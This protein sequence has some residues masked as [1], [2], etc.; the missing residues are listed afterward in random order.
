[1]LTTTILIAVAAIGAVAVAAGGLA[2]PAAEP[3]RVRA[4]RHR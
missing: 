1:M 2:A 4:D 3:V